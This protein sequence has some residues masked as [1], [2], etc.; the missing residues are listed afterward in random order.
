M[1]ARASEEDYAA[2]TAIRM[3][4]MTTENTFGKVIVSATLKNGMEGTIFTSLSVDAGGK[5][6]TVPAEQLQDAARVYPASITVSSE[7]GY[8]R[9]GLGPY[10]YI[11]YGGHDGT[12]PA[13]Y[14]VIFG[15]SGFKEIQKDGIQQGG[16][17][18]PPQGVGSPDP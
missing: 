5:T 1:S 11:R 6:L 10:L 16:P 15:P 7:V 8:P 13:K 14:C 2:I 17:G 3:E 12:K 18:Y 9:T 4:A